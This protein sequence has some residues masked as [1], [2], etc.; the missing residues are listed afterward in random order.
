MNFTLAPAKSPLTSSEYISKPLTMSLPTWA[1]GPVIGAMKPMIS[2]CAAAP[3][4][5][6]RF[7]PNARQVP[8][9]ISQVR[10]GDLFVIVPTPFA[11]APDF[12]LHPFNGCARFS[13][14]VIWGQ[15]ATGEFERECSS[16]RPADIE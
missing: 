15:C 4:L 5:V 7:V 11:L 10:L 2:S 14:S 8:I 12:G 1:N 16:N 3:G 13:A 6:A 9:N